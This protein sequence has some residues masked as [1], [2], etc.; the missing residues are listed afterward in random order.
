MF[1]IIIALSLVTFMLSFRQSINEGDPRVQTDIIGLALIACAIVLLF[2]GFSNLNGWGR[3]MAKPT[4]PFTLNGLL[5]A[6]GMIVLGFILLQG[7]VVWNRN[8]KNHGRT[9]LLAK[10]V[11]D[12]SSEKT[13][14]IVM[15]AVVAL[16]IFPAR[17]LRV[18]LQAISRFSH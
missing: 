16:A 6:H 14:A 12:S 17:K 8:T 5:P 3:L 4:V 13:A 7:F 11:M 10:K 1:A 15:F 9:P 18:T 2:M